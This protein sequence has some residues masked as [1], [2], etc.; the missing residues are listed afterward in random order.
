MTNIELAKKALEIAK[1]YKTLYVMGCFG[2]PLTKENKKRYIEEQ[3]Y[4]RNHRKSIENASQDTFGF[5]CVNLVKGILWGWN[6]DKEKTYG[7][8]KYNTKVCPDVSANNMIVLCNNVK[9]N[10]WENIEI[11]EVVW[12]FGHIG[13][14]V[15]N[16]QVVEATPKWFNKVQVSELGNIQHTGN[17]YRVWTRHGKLPWI[18]Y[19]K[20]EKQK[21]NSLK[22]GDIVNFNGNIHYSNA[23]SGSGYV[24]KPGKAKITNIR[25]DGIHKYHLVKTSNSSS[26]VFGW[27]DEKYIS[28]EK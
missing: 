13:I 3:E 7:G 24:A 23:W 16:N 9:T 14:Y 12:I 18:E 6:G 8:A 26:T 22:I 28:K 15:G 20:E 27:V 17:Q 21:N 19:V 10:D 4:N 2:A 1:N 5:D 11:G 25:N